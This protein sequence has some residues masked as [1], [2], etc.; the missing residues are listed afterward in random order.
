MTRRSR[1][2]ASAS[3]GGRRGS[4]ERVAGAGGLRGRASAQATVA[5]EWPAAPARAPGKPVADGVG[6]WG[7]RRPGGVRQ[8]RSWILA[9]TS[10]KPSSEQQAD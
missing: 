10:T 5:A 4:G 1:A 8:N 7:G 6:R 3:G 9:C 2:S